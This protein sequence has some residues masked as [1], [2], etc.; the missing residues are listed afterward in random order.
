MQ[1]QKVFFRKTKKGGIL[2]VVREHYLRDDIGCGSDRC[3]QCDRDDANE[4]NP[5]RLAGQPNSRSS[6]FKKPHYLVL[7]TNVV[8]NQ[9]DLLESPEGLR[10]VVLP[11][12]VL[13]ESRHRSTPVYKRVRD[14]AADARRRFRVFFNEHHRDTYVARRR[15]ESANDRND[16]AVRRVAQWLGEHLP[17]VQVVLLTEDRECRRKAEA[18]GLQACSTAEY[19]GSLEDGPVLAD[20]LRAAGDTEVGKKFLFPGHLSPAEINAG[21]RA[22]TL[23]QGV[24]YLS[25]TNFLEGTVNCELLDRPVLVQGLESMNRAVD[26]D[27][28][29]FELLNEKEWS[30]PAEVVLE[31]EGYD[32]GDSL[33]AE[34]DKIRRA[35]KGQDIQPT[36]KVVGIV[37]RKWRQY[38]G[39]LQPSPVKGAVKHIFVPAE[40]KIPKIRIETRQSETLKGQRIIVAIDSWPRHSRYPLGHF[41]RA[42]GAV[43][44]KATENEVLLLEHDV[45]HSKF[46]EAVLDCLPRLPWTITPDDE[47][48]RVDCRHL[49]ICSVDPPGCTDIDD[50]LHCRELPDGTLDVGVHIADVS[51]FIRPGTPIDKE[52]ANRSTTV[53]LTDR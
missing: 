42:L 46:S 10:N 16:R 49:D 40:K 9:I 31:D 38:C 48:E 22:K 5:G 39:I 27:T 32:A 21:I 23:R 18:E 25:R 45:P 6:L 29:V 43:G 17:G 8:L 36:G 47:A 15:G 41:V 34:E 52:A 19:V 13:E 37:R 11:Q 12:T 53:Y 3:D 24:F 1:T 7:D 51:H 30:A 44:D 2:K 14:V 26:G 50:A 33:K 35:A 4:R 20:K 28:V